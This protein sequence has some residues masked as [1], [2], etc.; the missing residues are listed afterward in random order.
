MPYL[1][2]GAQ[3]LEAVRFV[4]IDRRHYATI[5]ARE[6]SFKTILFPVRFAGSQERMS[7]R[8]RS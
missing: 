5:P 1:K 2:D 7:Y 4:N 3:M 6:R 8:Q